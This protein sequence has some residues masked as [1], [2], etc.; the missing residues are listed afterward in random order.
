M[1]GLEKIR[2]DELV[3][4]QLRDVAQNL[5]DFLKVYYS[6]DVNPTT[7]IEEI[8]QSR[9]IDRVASDAFLE[10]LAETIAKDVPDSAV[11]QK[12]F[13]LKRLV[14]YYNLKGTNQSIIIF[15]QLFYD[16]LAKVYEPWSNVLE[17]SSN[18]IGSNKLARVRP[19]EGKDIFELEDKEITLENEF[20]VILASGYV[21]RITVEQ[22]EEILYTLHFDSGSTTG[23]FTPG[24][25]IINNGNIYGTTVESLQSINIV[26]GGSGFEKG[27]I[28][29]LKDKPFTTFQAKIISTDVDG[30]A[31]KFEIIQRGNGTG[32]GETRF[33]RN[34]EPL[35][36]QLRKKDGRVLN[37]TTLGAGVAMNLSLTFST[38]VDDTSQS[39]NNKGLLS[40]N[41]VLQD[42]NYYNKYTY[43]INVNIPFNEYKTSFQNLI[44]PVGYNLFNNLKLENI[45]PLQFKERSSVAEVSTVGSANFLPGG[46]NR[47]YSLL[48]AKMSDATPDERINISPYMGLSRDNYSGYQS[49]YQ[50]ISQTATGAF[51]YT[52]HKYLNAV[53][54][55]D[56][57]VAE[58]AG[59]FMEDFVN[60]SPGY[61]ELIVTNSQFSV[62]NGRYLPGDYLSPR[63]IGTLN[64]NQFST[65]FNGETY[66]AI[67]VRT[68]GAFGDRRFYLIDDTKST[69]PVI[70]GTY[71]GKII[72]TGTTN[73]TYNRTYE[74]VTG[75]GIF[76]NTTDGG[77]SIHP[78]GRWKFTYGGNNNIFS[79][80]SN[81]DFL[82]A[83]WTGTFISTEGWNISTTD[84]SGFPFKAVRNAYKESYPWVRYYTSLADPSTF[85]YTESGKWPSFMLN[86]TLAKTWEYRAPSSDAAEQTHL[87]DGLGNNVRYVMTKPID[88]TNPEDIKQSDVNVDG[89]TS[90]AFTYYSGGATYFIASRVPATSGKGAYPRFGKINGLPYYIQDTR[91]SFGIIYNPQS[92]D[93][94]SS[95]EHGRWRLSYYSPTASVFNEGDEHNISS[96]EI[97]G[98]TGSGATLFNSSSVGT[99]TVSGTYNSQPRWQSTTG[100]F[101]RFLSSTNQWEITDDGDGY[102]ISEVQTPPQGSDAISWNDGHKRPYPWNVQTWSAHPDGNGNSDQP[103][104]SN[105]GGGS[106]P[107]TNAPGLAKA[108]PLESI[109]NNTTNFNQPLD[110]APKSID[111]SQIAHEEIIKDD[112]YVV[113]F[114]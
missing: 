35:V 21:Q 73:S 62:A 47:L 63:V 110:R 20:G 96:F 86:H 55:T 41:I 53:T 97:S 8:T 89:Y 58:T 102:Y 24:F 101:I 51:P 42:G 34:D 3:P 78:D 109:A 16:K 106:L 68:D 6:Q 85:T 65:T 2:I 19:L 82:D 77:F 5:I 59:Y 32:P 95:T 111:T 61:R 7:F 69:W 87:Q 9:D 84:E 91:P 25:N 49:P 18:N 93:K 11:V 23:L 70:F 105:F 28:L 10:K 76:G 13:L 64:E 26:D 39:T 79:T 107:S 38:L 50:S 37:P 1:R 98:I 90:G 48:G 81:I 36:Y 103:V 60:Q 88:T 30:R 99:Y 108:R 92:Q 40:D 14:D 27:D 74:E 75:T 31:L 114:R 66:E 72:V 83:D 17:T 113:E 54:G 29:F 56:D 71:Q 52:P 12:T 80:N 45:P 46:T 33:I 22:Y 4:E 67:D 94:W 104:F 44:H 57:A 15:F 43:E 100:H 112:S